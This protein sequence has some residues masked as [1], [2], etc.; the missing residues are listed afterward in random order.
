MEATNI[1]WEGLANYLY[2]QG[3]RVSVVNP[4]RI[5]GFA[6]SQL[7][8][9]KTDKLDSQVIAAFCA[10]CHPGPGSPRLRANANSAA[11]CGT[12]RP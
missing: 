11:W 3:Y 6:M 4:A 10:A 1:Y 8:R 12:A 2:E 5:I 7:Q 9:N